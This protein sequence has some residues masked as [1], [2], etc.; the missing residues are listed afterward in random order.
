MPGHAQS[1]AEALATADVF[2]M[3]SDYEGVPAVIIEALAAGVP[4][5]ATDCSVSM[6]S[7][8]RTEYSGLSFRY[9][10]RRHLRPRFASHRALQVSVPADAMRAKAAQ[11]TI[12]RAAAPI[13][14]P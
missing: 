8:S 4:I 2:V 14:T 12:E 9:P 10:I 11:F 13:S 1:V 6:S 3:S 7:R 5:V